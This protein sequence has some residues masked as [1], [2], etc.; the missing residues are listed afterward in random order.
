MEWNGTQRN[1]T[2]WIE[3]Q[4]FQIRNRKEWFETERKWMEWIVCGL[5]SNL[6]ESERNKTDR[7]ETERIGVEFHKERNGTER[8]GT[9]HERQF[10]QMKWNG[11]ERNGTER[12]GMNLSHVRFSRIETKPNETEGQPDIFFSRLIKQN[13]SITCE[14]FQN[15]NRT[16]QN[17]RTIRCIFF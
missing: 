5:F 16:E 7:N 15:T 9:N 13:E 17:G 11:M 2:E 12:N 14:I 3:C 4:V 10:L 8:N 1:E 6:N